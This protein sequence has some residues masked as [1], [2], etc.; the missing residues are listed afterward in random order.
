[1]GGLGILDEIGAGADLRERV[2]IS[3]KLLADR[4]RRVPRLL[5]DDSD[6]WV[7]PCTFSGDDQSVD[8]TDPEF[9]RM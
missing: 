3:W 6:V 4:T 1:M 5:T 2:G 9:S 7:V 8:E